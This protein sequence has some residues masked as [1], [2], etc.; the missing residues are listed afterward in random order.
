MVMALKILISL[1]VAM[2]WYHLTQN[3]ETSIFFFVLMLV[4]FFIRPIAYQS[5]TDRQEFIEKYKRAKERQ[6]NLE[7]MRLQE[8]KKNLEEKKKRLEGQDK[9]VK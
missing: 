3:Q 4:I 2:A 1:G 8:K 5:P 7:N 9:K 6:L